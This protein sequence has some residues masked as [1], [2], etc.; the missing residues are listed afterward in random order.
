ML[1]QYNTE[2]A[3]SVASTSGTVPLRTV[4]TRGGRRVVER[5]SNLDRRG[6]SRKSNEPVGQRNGELSMHSSIPLLAVN[7]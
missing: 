5:M 1:R 6:V 7:E 3:T 4:G 2:G